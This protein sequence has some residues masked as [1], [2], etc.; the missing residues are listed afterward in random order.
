MQDNY[1]FSNSR[2]NPY[3]DRLRQEVVLKLDADTLAYFQ[4]L[5]AQT[6]I[7]SQNLMNTYLADCAANQRFPTVLWH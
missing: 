3:L 2:P 5:E 7:S 4:R 1:D 6:G